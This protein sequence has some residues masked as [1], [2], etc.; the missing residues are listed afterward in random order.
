M[1]PFPVAVLPDLNGHFF[2]QGVFRMKTSLVVNAILTVFVLSYVFA[3]W[4]FLMKQKQEAS[5][6][7]SFDKA[8]VR[9]GCFFVLGSGLSFIAVAYGNFPQMFI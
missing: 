8:I 7:T 4:T 5:F 6:I 1:S 3:A 9:G 2:G